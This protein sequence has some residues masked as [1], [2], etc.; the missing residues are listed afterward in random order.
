MANDDK[1]YQPGNSN[2]SS[3]APVNGPPPTTWTPSILK[4]PPPPTATI[5]LDPLQNGE[6]GPPGATG[7]RGAIRF[8]EWVKKNP[9]APGTPDYSNWIVKNYSADP[10]DNEYSALAKQAY[11]KAQQDILKAQDEKHAKED[12]AYSTSAAHE[13]ALDVQ[14]KKGSLHWLGPA[15][16]FVSYYG[17]GDEKDPGS[18]GA[19]LKPGGSQSSDTASADSGT[20]DV[21]AVTDQQYIQAGGAVWVGDKTVSQGGQQVGNQS[22]YRNAGDMMNDVYRWNPGQTAAFQKSLGLD[23]TGVADDKTVAAWKWAVNTARYYTAMGQKRSIDVILQQGKTSVG[24]GGGG[25]GGGASTAIPA[26]AA[27]RL[28]NQA[29]K[30]FAGREATADE[31]KSFLPAIR[32]SSGSSDFDATQFAT[33]WVRGGD[34]GAR[35]GEVANYQ[36]A[37]DYYSVVQ[38][39][40]GGG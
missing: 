36:A 3:P 21:E 2:D 4:Q 34:E 8:Q 40:L 22:V 23:V 33:D 38:Q 27:K 12:Q 39:L 7:P 9:F 5:T 20:D 25:G 1:R 19:S 14:Q 17:T 31:L 6:Q 16:S 26:D 18:L 29:M 15:G 24:G 13:R 35:S 10:Y 30:E 11:D 37:T 28:L 32:G